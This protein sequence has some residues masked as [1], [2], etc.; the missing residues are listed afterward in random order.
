MSEP[1]RVLTLAPDLNLGGGEN[2]ILNLARSV[3]PERIH[4]TVATLYARDPS[5]EANS[6]SLREEF[7]AAGIPVVDL[8][9][10]RPQ[11]RSRVRPLQR[12]HT[13]F[14]LFRAAQ[15]LRLHIL[16]LRAE[17]VDAHMDGTL[18]LAVAAAVFARVPVVATLYHVH[19]LP[20]NR[21]LLPLR[22]LSL[23]RVA[24]IITDS[25]ARA[26]DFAA[27]LPRFRKPI[28]MIP[29]GVALPPPA[30]TRQDIRRALGIPVGAEI[31]IGQVSGLIPIKGHHVLLEAAPRVFAQHPGAHLLF[32]GF[33]RGAEA[34]VSSLQSQAAKLGI[35]DRV[36]VASYAGS[37]ADVWSV[38]DVHVHASLFDSLPNAILEG[39]SLGRPAVV[40]RVGGVPDAVEDGRTGLVVPPN[41]AASLAEALLRLLSDPALAARLGAAAQARYRSRYTPQHC[42]RAV[43]HCLLTA[44]GRSVVVPATVSA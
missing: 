42:A 13:T 23:R 41:D 32:A 38:I 10:P 27:A 25:E 43:E 2:R 18:L 8:N 11:Q 24:A 22:L 3:D 39:M 34:Y 6:G 4:L 7:A 37:I 26:A 15:Q 1:L 36:H 33:A 12:L 21:W 28:H 44:A 30:R 14:T 20:P 17:V 31:V 19:T 35:A 29:N 9:L 40:T 16:S 5:L